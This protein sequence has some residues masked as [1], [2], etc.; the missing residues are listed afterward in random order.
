MGIICQGEQMAFH[1]DLKNVRRV[2]EESM[3]H[4]GEAVNDG[5]QGG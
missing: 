3:A 4:F 1:A 2:E 5:K